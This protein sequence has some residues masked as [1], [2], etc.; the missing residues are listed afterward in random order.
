MFLPRDFPKRFRRHIKT[1]SGGGNESR[2][3]QRL[4]VVPKDGCVDNACAQAW[5]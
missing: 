1:G 5:P 2:G 4:D 3:H